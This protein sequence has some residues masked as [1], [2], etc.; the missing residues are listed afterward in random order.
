MPARGTA[1]LTG[2]AA[3]P[4]E[5]GQIRLTDTRPVAPATRTDR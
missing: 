3:T 4:T 5:P 2:P 1:T